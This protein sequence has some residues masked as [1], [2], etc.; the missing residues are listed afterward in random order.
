MG[1]AF[2][3]NE[4]VVAWLHET[5]LVWSGRVGVEVPRNSQRGWGYRAVGVISKQTQG[6]G[7]RVEVRGKGTGRVQGQVYLE[8]M[9]PSH[10]HPAMT[11]YQ[12]ARLCTLGA[13]PISGV[14]RIIPAF[15]CG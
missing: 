11:P 9:S 10:H 15:F 7:A 14:S 13:G 2:R 8:E 12:K 6:G 1:E 5:S 3:L 4:T